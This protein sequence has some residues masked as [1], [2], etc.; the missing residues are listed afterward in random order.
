MLPLPDGRLAGPLRAAPSARKP[1]SS[2]IVPSLL[3]MPALPCA[4]ASATVGGRLRRV[5][6]RGQAVLKTPLRGRK[7]S[8]GSQVIG[9]PMSS[10]S[11]AN[12]LTRVIFCSRTR[13]ARQGAR[14]GE[15][16]DCN[17]H[18]PST[19]GH[20]KPEFA[21][22]LPHTLAS[23]PCGQFA[24]RPPRERWHNTN[25]STT[26]IS[27]HA[28]QD[29]HLILHSSLLFKKSRQLYLEPTNCLA[30]D[31][32]NRPAESAGA[33]ERRAS[34]RTLLSHWFCALERHCSPPAATQSKLEGRLTRW[35]LDQTSMTTTL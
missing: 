2:P 12:K 9:K 8:S 21:S 31:P 11:S 33:I 29:K 32:P 22:S 25:H 27:A 24:G 6:F 14:T 30:A 15:L 35:L 16:R 19:G 7:G 4:V 17:G 23:F 10:P 1:L 3:I 18:T 34:W 26:L 20:L 28:P 5:P 13:F